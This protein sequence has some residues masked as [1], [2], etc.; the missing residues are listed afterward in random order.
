MSLFGDVAAAW[1]NE[2]DREE[3]DEKFDEQRAHQKAK[4]VAGVEA[5]EETISDEK[6][7]ELAK[8]AWELIDGLVVTYV[9]K[10]YAQNDDDRAKLLPV[11]ARMM[12]KYV[13]V[14]MAGVGFSLEDWIPLELLF[15][16]TVGWVYW[17]KYQV[18]M[19]ELAKAKAANDPSAPAGTQTVDASRGIRAVS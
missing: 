6:A 17:V 13:P 2:E 16:A 7:A 5:A 4:K 12:K 10:A 9:D 1:L 14:D 3:T 19:A 15:I 11:T 8:D 18:A